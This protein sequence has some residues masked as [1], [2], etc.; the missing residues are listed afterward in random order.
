MAFA[1]GLRLTA[2]LQQNSNDHLRTVI[3]APMTPGSTPAR[4][5]AISEAAR[6]GA[7]HALAEIFAA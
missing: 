6:A 5:G 1:C 3:V 4:L 2:T 7:V